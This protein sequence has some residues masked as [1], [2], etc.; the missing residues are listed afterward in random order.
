[1][2][3]TLV[4]VLVALAALYLINRTEWGSKLF[5]TVKGSAQQ[6]ANESLAQQKAQEIWNE[7]AEA[8]NM[9]EFLTGAHISTIEGE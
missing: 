3:E 4:A 7:N 6:K 9:L 8:M 2:R 1:M 5:F